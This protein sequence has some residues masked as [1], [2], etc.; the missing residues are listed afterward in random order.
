MYPNIYCNRIPLPK[1]PLKS[2]NSYIIKSPE[3]NLIID[4]GFN[5][6]ECEAAFS[7]G[8]GFYNPQHHLLEL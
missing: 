7:D 3:R 8:V 1:N 5:Q 4:T 6:P 2:L